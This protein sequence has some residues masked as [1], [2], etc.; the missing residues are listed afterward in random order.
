MGSPSATAKSS[1]SSAASMPDPPFVLWC[2]PSLNS[3]V[4]LPTSCLWLRSH[5]P[6]ETGCTTGTAAQTPPRELLTCATSCPQLRHPQPP[7]ALQSSPPSP[8]ALSSYKTNAQGNN[9]HYTVT[10]LIWNFLFPTLNL[11]HHKWSQIKYHLK[12]KDE[13]N[14]TELKLLHGLGLFLHRLKFLSM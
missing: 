12:Q 1:D 10:S 8:K 9:F 7:L 6:S 11:S 2:N 13:L 5:D 14:P 4:T 3:T